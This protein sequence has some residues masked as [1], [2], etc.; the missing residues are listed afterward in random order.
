[1]RLI[2]MNFDCCSRQQLTQS[3]MKDETT[4]LF[5]H[6]SFLRIDTVLV[7][8]PKTRFTKA[9]QLVTCKLQRGRHCTFQIMARSHQ[10]STKRTNRRNLPSNFFFLAITNPESRYIRICRP[11]EMFL[12]YG[13]CFSYHLRE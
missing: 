9:L 4:H 2:L 7:W 6:I 10:L 5:V 8:A 3:P 13:A 11:G 1:M 12:N